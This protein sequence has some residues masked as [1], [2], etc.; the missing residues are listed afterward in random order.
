MPYEWQN[1]RAHGLSEGALR[2]A[3]REG[4]RHLLSNRSGLKIITINKI[5]FDILFAGFGT[6]IVIIML[7][8]GRVFAGTSS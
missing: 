4:G 1:E 7:D 6:F 5:W 8:S 3:E 2:V